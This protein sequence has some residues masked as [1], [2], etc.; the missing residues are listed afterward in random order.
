MRIGRPS[1]Q[2]SQHRLQGSSSGRA[3]LGRRRRR[4]RG[5]RRRSRR[6]GQKQNRSR[7]QVV[8]AA[9]G[10]NRAPFMKNQRRNH[11]Q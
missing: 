7:R 8:W 5:S 11:S 1:Y 6:R 9:A 4:R 2:P 10:C 3:V